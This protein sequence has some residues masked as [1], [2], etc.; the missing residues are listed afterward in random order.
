MIELIILLVGLTNGML[1]MYV[2]LNKPIVFRYEYKDT[3]ERT[4]ISTF[5]P[6]KESKNEKEEEFEAMVEGYQYVMQEFAGVNYENEDEK[7]RR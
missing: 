7:G 2:I 3:T 5:A 1:L 6:E 4:S